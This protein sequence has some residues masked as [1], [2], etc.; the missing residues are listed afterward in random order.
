[1]PPTDEEIEATRKLSQE[2]LEQSERLIAEALDP[3]KQL[4]PLF[5]QLDNQVRELAELG[6]QETSMENAMGCLTAA[7]TVIAD[8]TEMEA[9]VVDDKDGGANG[10]SKPGGTAA[11]PARR[12]GM[13]V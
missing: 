6:S 3:A 11:R 2:I 13:R 7:A 5:D 9:M 12:R 4:G 8:W 1:M 10:A